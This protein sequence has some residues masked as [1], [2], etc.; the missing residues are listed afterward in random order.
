MITY[1]LLNFFQILKNLIFKCHGK[2][3][4]HKNKICTYIRNG[5]RESEIYDNFWI[6]FVMMTTQYFLK[7]SKMSKFSDNLDQNLKLKKKSKIKIFHNFWKRKP[8]AGQQ[9]IKLKE[10]VVFVHR[11]KNRLVKTKYT[12]ICSLFY[13]YISLS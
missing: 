6:T 11:H 5:N 4:D 10:C 2:S 1:Q 12:S 9:I 3:H 8:K 7:I 13:Y